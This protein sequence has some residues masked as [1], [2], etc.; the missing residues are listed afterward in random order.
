M[1]RVNTWHRRNFRTIGLVQKLRKD[2]SPS[3][4]SAAVVDLM[5]PKA[6]PG[7]L[8]DKKVR[9]PSRRNPVTT[10]RIAIGSIIPWKPNVKP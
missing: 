2:R 3:L 9:P 6:R 8:E 5:L 4:V 1:S 10:Q 7:L